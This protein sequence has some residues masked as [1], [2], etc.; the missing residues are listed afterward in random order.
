MSPNIHSILGIEVGEISS[1]KMLLKVLKSVDLFAFIHNF[2]DSQ[3][4]TFS[5]NNVD[6]E[7]I[8]TW[9]FWHQKWINRSG[10][11]VF[12]NPTS[13]LVIKLI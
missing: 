5:P 8:W 7:K 10:L 13:F 1:F 11:F 4:L 9:Y 6:T 12:L 2:Q 3:R